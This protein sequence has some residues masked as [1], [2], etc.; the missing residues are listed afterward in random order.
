MKMGPSYGESVATERSDLQSSFRANQT[1]PMVLMLWNTCF[2]SNHALEH[3]EKNAPA[4]TNRAAFK[5]KLLT[6]E[7]VR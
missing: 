1:W 4:G 6:P 3:E 7:W 5:C 2:I